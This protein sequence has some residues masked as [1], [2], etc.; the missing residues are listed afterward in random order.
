MSHIERFL[1]YLI[2][3][4]GLSKNTLEA[5]KRDIGKFTKFIT[6][7]SKDILN[8]KRSDIVGFI[9]FL[10]ESNYSSPSIARCLASIRG[11]FRFL[12][13]EKAIDEDP[14]EDLQTLQRW[15]RLPKAISKTEVEGILSAPGE[16]PVEIR[17]AAMLELLYS[18]GLRVS[19]LVS[20]NTGDINFEAGFLTVTG[21]GSKQRVVPVNDIAIKKI[22]RYLSDARPKIIK[23]RFSPYL[24]LAQGGRPMTRQRFWQAMKGYGRKIGIEVSP[25]TLR[26]S[27][28]TH[29]L[30]GGAD[31]RSV[32]KM[33]GHADISTT[34]I[35]TKVSSETLKKVIKEFHPR[36]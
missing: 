35:Y 5:Y 10:R 8:L 21:K 4:K 30:E 17:N 33:L 36:G 26:H 15:Q 25:H 19:E 28:A 31:L 27:F 34:Q 1:D 12:Q 23:G 3:E 14:T 29:L 11:L 2:V 18:S 20:L 9:G 16:K 7:D 13:I 32:Q 22:N 6:E 24:F